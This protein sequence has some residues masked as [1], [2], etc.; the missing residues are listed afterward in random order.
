MQKKLIAALL[1]VAASA[2]LVIVPAASASPVLTNAK[3]EAVPVG[4]EIKATAV[5]NGVFTGGFNVVCTGSEG[6][7]VVTANTGTSV[8]GEIPA[9]NLKFSGT[10]SGGE[11]TS[12]L[13]NVTVSVNSKIC[14]ETTKGT[15]SGVSTGCGNPITFSFAVTGSVTCRYSNLLDDGNLLHSAERRAGSPLGTIG[16]RRGRQLVLLPHRRQTRHFPLGITENGR[17]TRRLLEQV[18]AVRLDRAGGDGFPADLTLDGGC[19]AAAQ[20][21]G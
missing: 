12:S 13:G 5:G 4:T 1:A 10:G 3:G 18:L 11:C 15:D 21:L 20:L 8:K 14:S 7:G 9:N 17:N 19:G 16:Q 6:S 2:A